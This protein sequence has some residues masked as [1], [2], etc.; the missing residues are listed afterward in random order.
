MAPIKHGLLGMLMTFFYLM[1]S[2]ILPAN[3]KRILV[4]TSLHAQLVQRGVFQAETLHKL[5]Q[6]L[7]LAQSDRALELPATVSGR[8]WDATQ[9]DT[10]VE[11]IHSR[12]S[13]PVCL[14]YQEAK[15]VSESIVAI[16]P[17][18]LRYDTDDVMVRD[19][20]SLFYCQSAG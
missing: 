18:W 11:E 1:L 3:G 19:T 20:I 9:L 6:S 12:A 7:C 16:L 15:R 2:F 14:P 10:I 4:L 17:R 8:L 5:N 13:G